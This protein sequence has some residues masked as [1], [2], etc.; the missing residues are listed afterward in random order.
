MSGALKLVQE[1]EASSERRRH[2][3]QRLRTLVYTELDRE[4]GGIV[5]DASEGGI[6]VHAVVPLKDEILPNVRLNLPEPTGCLETRARVIWTREEGKVAGLQF[7]DLPLVAQEQIREWISSE[8]STLEGM[9]APGPVTF[10][11][12]PTAGA[13]SIAETPENPKEPIENRSTPS[14]AISSR[15]PNTTLRAAGFEPPIGTNE[16]RMQPIRAVPQETSNPNFLPEERLH[17]SLVYALLIAFA[18]ISLASGWAA[19]TGRLRAF[20]RAVRNSITPAFSG[21]VAASETASQSAPIID[22]AILGLDGQQRTI[23]LVAASNDSADATP[24]PTAPTKKIMTVQPAAAAQKPGMNFQIWTLTSPQA[25]TASR[26]LSTRSSTPPEV[27]E[28]SGAPEIP[29]VGSSPIEVTA[30]HAVLKPKITTGVLKHGVLIHRVDPEYPEI[31]RQQNISGT[32]MLQATVG[33]DGAV[34]AVRVISGSKL[35]V[36]SAVNAVRQWRYAPTLLDGKAVPT[37]VEINIVF[38]PPNE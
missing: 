8:A 36:Q 34:R 24:K 9:G 12:E 15:A 27:K 25:S 3:R 38:N 20:I 19:G 18:V 16:D 22:I 33:A 29:V 26:V 1:A 28:Y 11:E 23:S 14:S 6:S 17:K 10:P 7:E 32:V 35:L 2:A 30:P 5:L 21:P 31:A 4:N 13:P 37:Q